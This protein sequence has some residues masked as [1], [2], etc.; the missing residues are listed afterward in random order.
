MLKEKLPGLKSEH[1][2]L[3]LTVP[4]YLGVEELADSGIKLKFAA[5]VA[6]KD[7]FDGQRMLARDLKLLF[8]DNGISIPFPQVVIH[9]P[10]KK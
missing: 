3:Y 6:E 9:V 7:I 4:R 1:P 2:D 10:N 5:D 8:D